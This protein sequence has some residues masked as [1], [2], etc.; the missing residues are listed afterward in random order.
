MIQLTYRG[1]DITEDVFIN[2]CY[3]DMYAAG[4]SDEL[5]LRVNDARNAWDSWAPAIGDEI[6]VDYGSVGTGAMFVSAVVPMNGIYEIVARSAPPSGFVLNSKAWQKVRFLQLA[7]EIAER[8][9]LEFASYGVT[10]VLYDYIL[11]SGESDFHFLHRIA[12]LEGCAFLVY[13]KRL[14]LYSEAYMEAQAPAEVLN[15][16][17]DGDYKYTDARERMYGSCVIERGIYTGSFTAN[18]GSNRVFRPADVSHV[19]SNEEARR[20]A[21]NLLRAKN[22]GC[23][24]GFVRSRI[25]PGYAAASTIELANVRAPSWDGAVFLDHIRNDYGAGKSKLFFRRPLEGY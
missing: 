22:K 6:K 4:R 9:G 8:N 23:C 21:K 20:F 12:Q 2:S 15:V 1:V 5:H 25:L 19:N 10:D 18:N 16:T 11:Q 14:V 7:A 24:S 17:V 3:H 13:D